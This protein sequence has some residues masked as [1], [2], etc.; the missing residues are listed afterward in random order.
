MAL[1]WKALDRPLASQITSIQR[2]PKHRRRHNASD[3]SEKIC[4]MLTKKRPTAPDNV[5]LGC[6]IRTLRKRLNKTIQDVAT[7]S[8]LSKG[9]LSQVERGQASPSLSSLTDIATACGVTI[10][11]FFNQ[12]VNALSISYAVSRTFLGNPE[13]A[14]CFSHLTETDGNGQMEAV[15]IRTP[16]G[17]RCVERAAT[18]AE[19]LI[20]VLEGE[21]TLT[22]D[23]EKLLLGVD[24]FIQYKTKTPHILQ[25]TAQTE[26]TLLWIGTSNNDDPKLHRCAQ[27]HLRTS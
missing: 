21:I 6:K 5:R 27:V 16:S 11:Y 1:K 3:R 23:G 4:L 17:E 9:Y 13:S 26:A 12:S 20:Y 8:G 2:N 14:S 22:L 7:A 18:S 24:D 15:L 19:Q 10:D 25:N